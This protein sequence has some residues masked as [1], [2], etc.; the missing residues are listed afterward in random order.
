MSKARKL[1]LVEDHESVAIGLATILADYPD[2]ELVVTASTVPDLLDQQQQLDLVILDLR[3]GDGSSPKSNVSL[4]HDHGLKVLAFT[5]AENP[6]LVRSAAR[7]GVLGVVRKSEPAAAV[8]DAIRRAAA[9]EQVVT[10]DWA[11]AIDGDPHLPNVGLSPR[12]QE[13]LALYA[14]GEKATRV[15]HLT[16]LAEQTVYDYLARI[17]QK[18]AEA[19]RP[20]P[21]KTDLFKRAVEDGWLPVPEHPSS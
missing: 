7:A 16:G 9:G 5:G 20:A 18:Y 10:T 19:G 15:A 3:L 8:V 4:L 13:V 17:R 11:A 21:T 2:L 1:G 12:Q 6:Y 14:S